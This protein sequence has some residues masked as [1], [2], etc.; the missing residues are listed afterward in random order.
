MYVIDNFMVAGGLCVLIIAL[1]IIIRDGFVI[2]ELKCK[3]RQQSEEYQA[4]LDDCYETIETL[5]NKIRF[6]EH[7]KL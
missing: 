7:S 4:K 6:H 3:N 5:K 2:S 1:L